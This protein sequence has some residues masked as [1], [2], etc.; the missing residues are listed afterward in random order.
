MVCVAFGCHVGTGRTFYFPLKNPKL[1]AEWVRRVGRKD[2]VPGKN[3]YLCQKHFAPEMFLAPEQNV[4]SR[5]RPRKRIHL[6]EGAIPTIFCD[7]AG[8]MP[9]KRKARE[10]LCL[11]SSVKASQSVVDL[12]HDYAE[13]DRRSTSVEVD[14]KSKIDRLTKENDRLSVLL[15]KTFNSDQLKALDPNTKKVHAWSEGTLKKS[16]AKLLM[17]GPTG[18]EHCRSEGEPLPCI[19]TLHSHLAKIN[20]EP[21][22]LEDMFVLLSQEVARMAEVDKYCCLMIDEMA[23]QS[24]IEYDQTTQSLIGHPTMLASSAAASD[25]LATHA[26]AFVLG[27]CSQRRWKMMVAYEFTGKS[28]CAQEAVRLLGKIV[29]RSSQIGVLVKSLS[30]DMGPCNQAI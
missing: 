22:L 13:S 10:P 15:N 9:K 2:F 14:Q 1:C 20:F 18:Y 3:S 8:R 12:D 28:F 27:S 4:D 16:I 25:S 17:C 19:R 26:L 23:I 29:S 11:S 21:G 5:G 7:K 24:C 30:M 6:V